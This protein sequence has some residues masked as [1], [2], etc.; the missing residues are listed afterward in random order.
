MSGVEIEDAVLTITEEDTARFGHEVNRSFLKYAWFFAVLLFLGIGA[1]TFYLSMIEGSNLS[2]RAEG[3]SVRL[4]PIQAPR[5][6]VFDRS[7]K[8]LVYNVPSADVVLIASYLPDRETVERDLAPRLTD[9][10]H[11]SPDEVHAAM[12]AI[13]TS[14]EPRAV[15]KENISQ[16]EALRF[17]EAQQSFPGVAIVNRVRRKY[18]DSAIFSHVIG[19]EGKIT[20]EELEKY[21]DYHL[22]DSLGRL[23]IERSHEADLRGTRGA[24]RVEVDSLGHVRREISAEP[25]VPGS[26]LTLTIDAELQKHLFD[27]MSAALEKGDLKRGAAVAID[28][29]SGEVLALVSFPSYDNN[30]FAEGTDADEYGRLFSDP[31]TP[32]FDRAISGEYAPGSTIKPVIAA[33]ALQEGVITDSMHIDGYGGAIHVGGSTF[34]DWAVHGSSDVRLAIAQ[35]NDIFF[36]SIGGGYGNVEGL[37]MSRMKQYD[38]LFGLGKVTG[39]DLPGERAGFIPDE[40]WK[41]ETLGEKWYIGNSYHAAIGQGFITATPLQ[42]ALTASVFANGGTLYRP[43]V[44]S[45][46][47]RA[48]GKVETHVPDAERANLVSDAAIRAVREGMRETVTVGTAQSLQS[49]PVEIAGKTGTA[50]FGSDGKTH[51][52]FISFAPY[53]NPVIAM[54]VLVEGQDEDGYFAV[55]ITKEVYDWYFGEKH[56]GDL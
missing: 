4:I 24:Y 56:A 49:S 28:P 17:S 51:G 9:I 30:I 8:Q 23:G 35:S 45:Q 27:S 15:L 42:M 16:D 19:Y 36:Y 31:D 29:R 34:H 55:P 20:A 18:E 7:G 3:N 12:D 11:V 32:L 53:D 5:G 22:T 52:W 38:E 10:F 50:Q 43:F 41:K 13:E 14:G 1:R 2:A 40:A 47:R 44:V 26:D 39:I 33:S 6:Q 37:G 21:P 46:L 48:D 54:A 25:P